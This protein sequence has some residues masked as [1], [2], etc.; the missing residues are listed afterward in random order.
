VEGVSSGLRVLR[1]S[2]D[3]L[4]PSE[5]GS[6]VDESLDTIND[7]YLAVPGNVATNRFV[8]VPATRHGGAMSAVAIDGHVLKIA[9][10]R[11]PA[12]LR[13]LSSEADRRDL[14]RFIDALVEKE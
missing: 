10:Q 5:K 11:P 6:V 8:D 12:P 9:F 14:Q 4:H 3:C 7:G 2:S 13:E 1:K